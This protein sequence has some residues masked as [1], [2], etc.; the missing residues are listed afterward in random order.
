MFTRITN[1]PFRG[2]FAR[3]L[4]QMFPGIPNNVLAQKLQKKIAGGGLK[5]EFER[6]CPKSVKALV[7]D[8]TGKSKLVFK[9]IL[10][11]LRSEVKKEVRSDEEQSNDLKTLALG[12]KAELARTSI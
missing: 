4:P 7:S 10:E 11:R 9:D 1:N 2:R 5:L 6:L 12:E 3:A 8:C